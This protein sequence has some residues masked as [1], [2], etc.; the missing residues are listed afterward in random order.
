MG[1]GTAAVGGGTAAVGGGRAVVGG[2]TA[3]VGGGTAVFAVR[4][5]LTR[6]ADNIN[7]CSLLNDG[8]PVAKEIRQ[9]YYNDWPVCGFTGDQCNGGSR[10]SQRRVLLK[11]AHIARAKNSETRPF[12]R[13]PRLL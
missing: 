3:A 7:G 9:I 1:G 5:K 12:A 8:N 13:W 2:G 6:E 4:S 10:I 11:K